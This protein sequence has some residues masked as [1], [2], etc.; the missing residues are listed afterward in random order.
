MTKVPK[1]NEDKAIEEGAQLL[2]EMV[3][4][5]IAAGLVT[6]EYRRSSEKEEAKQVLELGRFTIQIR[7][8]DSKSLFSMN[9]WI[10][11]RKNGPFMTQIAI[12]IRDFDSRI[13]VLKVISIRESQKILNRPSPSYHTRKY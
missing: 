11:I 8:Y 1:L 7:D 10:M 12:Q 6:F 5:S 2:S 4:L 3:I 9:R 13:T